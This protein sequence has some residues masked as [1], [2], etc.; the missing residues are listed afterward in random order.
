MKKIPI[1]LIYS[2]LLSGFAMLLMSVSGVR[3]P[4]AV[5]VGLFVYGLVSDIFD[6]IIAR[7]LGVSTEKMRR[8]DSTADNIFYISVIA[9]VFILNPDFMYVHATK[10]IILVCAEAIVYFVSYVK[11]GREVATHAIASKFWSLILFATLTSLML[12]YDTSI[13]FQWCFYVGLVTR[14]EIL[15][16]L[17]V[18]KKWTADVPSF[19][20]A[21]QLRK[22]KE[23]KRNKY[24]NG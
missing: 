12:E 21:I 3:F 10:L 14:L 23:I 7:R 16:I 9:S 22:G 1:V 20:H 5:Y 11:F 15:V 4:K 24:F 13:L 19:Y 18:L 17:L 2:R 6:G 8:M